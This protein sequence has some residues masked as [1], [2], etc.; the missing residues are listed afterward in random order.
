MK[1]TK[2]TEIIQNEVRNILSE[3]NYHSIKVGDRVTI[4]RNL[5]A[6]PVN[7][8]GETGVVNSRGKNVIVYVLFNDGIVGGY[9]E[10]VFDI[11]GDTFDIDKVTKEEVENQKELN[12][13]LEKTADLTNK[14]K[15]NETPNPELD[16][17]VLNFIK[18]IAKY[19]DYSV[20]D[21]FNTVEQI[22]NRLKN[23]AGEGRMRNI[24]EEDD[25]LEPTTDDLKKPDS[26][27][28]MIQELDNI[29]KEMRSLVKKW[30]DAEG[31]E[32]EN[33]KNELKKLTKLKN[34]IEELI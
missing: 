11:F 7:K 24:N 1:K 34:E 3:D 20:W 6:D 22:M 33:I 28:T 14:I 23:Y 9:L 17:K 13:E 5:T 32:K 15:I 4:P 16:R 2:L 12:K 31:E 26:V 27:I 21:A 29:T 25:D 19:Y 10:S 8:Q 18:S 30:K